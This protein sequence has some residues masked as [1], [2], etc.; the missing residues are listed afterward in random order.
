VSSFSIILRFGVLIRILGSF[1]SEEVRVRWVQTTSGAEALFAKIRD[2][3]NNGVEAA[4]ESLGRILELLGG[5]TEA[6]RQRASEKVD[7]K[8]KREKMK[9]EL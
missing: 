1:F 9:G 5:K 2:I 6:A 7:E 3:V 8:M 4:E